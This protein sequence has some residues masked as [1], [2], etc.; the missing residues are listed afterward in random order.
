MGELNGLPAHILLV[1]AVV[2]LVPLTAIA[3]LLVA[4]WAPAR[5]RFGIVGPLL[6]LVT[7]ATVPL[8][9][10]AGQWL[11]RRVPDTSLVRQ[12]VRLGDTLLPWVLALGLLSGLVWWMDGASGR[13]PS[14]GMRRHQLE[15]T[16]V[17]VG[18]GVVSVVVAVDSVVTVYRIGDSGARAA[19]QGRVPATAAQGSGTGR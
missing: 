5:G 2:V 10:S 13:R 8:T 9:T 18:L 12:H 17:R 1:H 16:W 4:F 19:W 3:V 14:R 11:Q 15:H 7:L 6:G